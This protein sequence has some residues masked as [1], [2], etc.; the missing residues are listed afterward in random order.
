MEEKIGF[1]EFKY[2]I[3]RLLRKMVSYME[4]AVTEGNF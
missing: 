4:D 3:L 2:L 1:S